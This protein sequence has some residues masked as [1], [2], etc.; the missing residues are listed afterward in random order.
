M[1]CYLRV[2]ES[3]IL[4][5]KQ[6]RRLLELFTSCLGSAIQSTLLKERWTD[7]SKEKAR[8]RT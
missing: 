4:I 3:N 2:E 6:G 8:E 7:R 1:K 5:S